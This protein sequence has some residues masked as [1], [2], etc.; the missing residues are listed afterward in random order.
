MPLEPI[1]SKMSIRGHPIHPAL[2][3]FPVAALILL[4]GADLGYILTEDVFWARAGLWLAGVGTIGGWVAGT[5]GLIDLVLVMRIRRLITAWS[6]A[7]LAVMMLSLAT[8]NWLLR[9]ADPV[10]FIVPW[11]AYLSLLTGALIAASAFLGGQLVYEYGVGV[12]T[13][14]AL[15]RRVKP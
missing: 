7:I 13:E 14:E 8:L 4:I 2:I 11:G 5:A 15:R 9:Y 3:H 10:V 6:H 1:L 12:N